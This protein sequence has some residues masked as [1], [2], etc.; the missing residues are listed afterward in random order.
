MSIYVI[1]NLTY[2][3]SYQIEKLPVCGETLL[4]NERMVDAGG[5]GLNQAIAAS[6]WGSEVHFVGPIGE[7]SAVEAIK[8]RIK[9][10]NFRNI[11]LIIKSVPTD[12]S[13][14]LLDSVGSNMIVSTDAAAK[15]LVIADI[16]RH[17]GLIK[18]TDTILLQGNLSQQ[19]TLECLSKCKNFQSRTILNPS[20][21]G[22][23]YDEILPLV[24][25]AVL[26]EV[27]ASQLGK[28]D[29]LDLAGKY[30]LEL[31]V[32]IVIITLG[33]EGALVIFEESRFQCTAPKT[34][35]VD[36]SGAGDA[37]VGSLASALDFG[38]SMEESV[39]LAVN[40]ASLTV[41][42][43]G[44]SSAFPSHAEIKNVRK[45]LFPAKNI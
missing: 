29:D 17:L 11:E 40:I 8:S 3:I 28:S 32:E 5:K 35:V 26:N 2:D 41:T 23:K 33:P 30:L 1:G 31:G 43:R 10:E 6:R 14:I 12:E 24:Q 19:T 22:F 27:E 15:A 16:Q 7:D 37:F 21:I 44:T 9:S 42:K 39:K 38:Y 34:N 20:P 25:I 18:R 45:N 4:A 13:I 36:T